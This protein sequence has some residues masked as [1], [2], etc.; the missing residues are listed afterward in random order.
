MSCCDKHDLT[1]MFLNAGMYLCTGSSNAS[2][3]SCCGTSP[4]KTCSNMKK[5]FGHAQHC[6]SPY[7]AHRLPQDHESRGSD[8]LCHRMTSEQG[9][10]RHGCPKFFVLANGLQT[11]RPSAPENLGTMSKHPQ[12]RIWTTTQFGV[13]GCCPGPF[14]LLFPFTISCIR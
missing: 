9:L 3:P 5:V 2:F 14:F 1:F 4:M 8:R 13:A 12:S 10:L 11:I 6:H 7:T